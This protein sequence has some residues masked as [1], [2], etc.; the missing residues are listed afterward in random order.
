M[1]QVIKR[2]LFSSLDT[3]LAAFAVAISP[4]LTTI[5]GNLDWPT[6]KSTL[7]AGGIAGLVAGVR[8]VFKMLRESLMGYRQEVI[9]NIVNPP[10]VSIGPSE[11]FTASS[12]PK[13]MKKKGGKKC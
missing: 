9:F 11:P 8:A 5:E 1:K 6:L 12:N 7:I 13:P 10:N 4:F 2:Y 3:F